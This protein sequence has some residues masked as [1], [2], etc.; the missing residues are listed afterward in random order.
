V[1]SR[2]VAIQSLATRLEAPIPEADGA[3]EFRFE[4]ADG[5]FLGVRFLP[6]D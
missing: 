1:I 4:L 3:G 6:G 5:M 2:N